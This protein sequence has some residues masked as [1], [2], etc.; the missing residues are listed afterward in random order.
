VLEK[1][2]KLQPKTKTIGELKVDLQIVWEEL[3]HQQDGGK[4][5]QALDCLHGCQWWP[6]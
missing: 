6:L 2:Y 5:H 4:L 3:P 1:Y